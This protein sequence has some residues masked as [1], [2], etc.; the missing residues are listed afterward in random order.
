MNSELPFTFLGG[1]HISALL[2]TAVFCV[3][4]WPVAKHLALNGWA[5]H[6]GKTLAVFLVGYECLKITLYVGVFKMPLLYHLP[7]HLCDVNMLLC[8][9]M[10]ARHSYRSYEVSYFWAMGGSVAAM[11]TPDLA[12]GFP[13]PVFI[14][15]F[16]GHGLVVVSVLYATFGYG[17]RPRLKSIAIAM[18]VTALYAAVIMPLNFL[19]DT[20]YLYL[21]AKPL[22][23]SVLD[24]L[25]PWPW[26][27]VGLVG[28]CAAACFITYAPFALARKMRGAG[29]QGAMG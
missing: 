5:Q 25:G 7:L 16:L 3:A 8:A 14:A 15:F 1:P 28:L 9:Y 2:I 13:H 19:L 29:N 10:L 18:S 4:V 21:R 11:L 17:F 20:N 27:I 24:Y 26:Y 6:F 22:T 12:Y 23:P